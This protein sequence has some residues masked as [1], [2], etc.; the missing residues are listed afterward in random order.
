MSGKVWYQLADS[1]EHTK[2]YPSLEAAEDGLKRILDRH[3]GMGHKVN[4]QRAEGSK[5]PLFIVEHEGE[6]IAKYRLVE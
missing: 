6:I 3:E 4:F 1:E 5:Q 2:L